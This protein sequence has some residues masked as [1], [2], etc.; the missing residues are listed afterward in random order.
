MFNIQIIGSLTNES[1][2]G[3]SHIFPSGSYSQQHNSIHSFCSSVGY[4]VLHTAN[5]TLN[6]FKCDGKN[7]HKTFDNNVVED[8]QPL[9]KSTEPGT[10]EESLPKLYIYIIDVIYTQHM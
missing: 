5:D 4:T 10:I 8:T 1:H 9:D 6:T 3:V 7:I 2:T